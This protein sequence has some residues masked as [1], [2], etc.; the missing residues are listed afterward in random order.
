MNFIVMLMIHMKGTGILEHLS[1]SEL[2]MLKEMML[3]IT[4][5]DDDD[6][7][8]VDDEIMPGATPMT[9][10]GRWTVQM[11]SLQK[12]NIGLAQNME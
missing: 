2:N 1:K 6:D 3:M 10:T 11:Q 5:V 4:P 8:Y 12:H 9:P 7:W